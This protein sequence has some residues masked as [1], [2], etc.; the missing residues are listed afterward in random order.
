MGRGA[1]SRTQTHQ[2]EQQRRERA[3]ALKACLAVG[4]WPEWLAPSQP[5]LRRRG[6]AAAV[7]QPSSPQQRNNSSN[8][9]S[10]KSS[11]IHTTSPTM[12][13]SSTFCEC[14]CA[15]GCL[16]CLLINACCLCGDCSCAPTTH[17]GHPHLTQT[18]PLF[19]HIC[20]RIFMTIIA[21]AAVGIL[22]VEGWGGFI[23]YLISQAV[24]STLIVQV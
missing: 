11:R 15:C 23:G 24:V 8:K 20:R 1:S 3:H 9:T 16:V 14:L 22:G 4:L 10:C 17:T 19:P 6:L 5:H 7:A 21:G 12:P 2:T 13:A 18:P